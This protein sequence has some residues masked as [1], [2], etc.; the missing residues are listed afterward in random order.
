VE[1]A[2]K[3]QALQPEAVKRASLLA[4]EGAIDHGANHYKI[5]LAPRVITRAILKVGGIA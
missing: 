2:L 1:K 3:G 4:M 5:E